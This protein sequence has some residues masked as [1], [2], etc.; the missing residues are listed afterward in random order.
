MRKKRTYTESI[1]T[2][3]KR[4][5]LRINVRNKYNEECRFRTIVLA[6]LFFIHDEIYRSPVYLDDQTKRVPEEHLYLSKYNDRF[7]DK[8]LKEKSRLMQES[9]AMNNI[10]PSHSSNNVAIKNFY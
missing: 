9:Y 2:L 8:L 7:Y 3:V 10:L 6:L 5:C 1:D 4:R